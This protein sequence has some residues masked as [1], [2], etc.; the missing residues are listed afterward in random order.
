VKEKNIYK[1]SLIAALRGVLFDIFIM[2]VFN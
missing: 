1:I 2:E